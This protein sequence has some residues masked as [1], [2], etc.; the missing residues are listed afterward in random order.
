LGWPE[1]LVP[2]DLKRPYTA[3]CPSH[4]KVDAFLIVPFAT[5]LVDSC[6]WEKTWQ[7]VV[8]KV[9]KA[10]P[11]Q[12]VKWELSIESGGH[13]RGYGLRVT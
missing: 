8:R 10:L 4:L 12:R 2:L 7:Q 3:I 11:R 5:V 13:V 6:T 9:L 1:L